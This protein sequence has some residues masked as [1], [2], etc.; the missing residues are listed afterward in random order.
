MRPGEPGLKSGVT[1]VGSGGG[2]ACAAWDPA[3][4]PYARRKRGFSRGP[5]PRPQALLAR[6]RRGRIFGGEGGAFLTL[7]GSRSTVRPARALVAVFEKGK[8]ALT[9]PEAPRVSQDWAG[10]L[11][12]PPTPGP[13][14]RPRFLLVAAREFGAAICVGPVPPSYRVCIWGCGSPCLVLWIAGIKHAL[15]STGSK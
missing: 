8:R 15:R 12:P 3:S 13:S 11:R 14:P 10:R 7:R 1:E 9:W 6:G 4:A 5:Y 2:V